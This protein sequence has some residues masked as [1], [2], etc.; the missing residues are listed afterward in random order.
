M[1]PVIGVVPNISQIDIADPVLNVDSDVLPVTAR[2]S[3]QLNIS[4]PSTWSGSKVKLGQV[5]LG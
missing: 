3:L 4:Q 2:G 1:S 5:M